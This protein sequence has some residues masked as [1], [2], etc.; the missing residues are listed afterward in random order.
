MT[1]DEAWAELQ[2]LAEAANREHW[3]HWDW[4]SW[5][6]SS[7]GYWQLD[8][9]QTTTNVALTVALTPDVVLRLIAA[10]R[11]REPAHTAAK[12]KT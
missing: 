3:D 2:Q 8:P 11:L 10:A 7:D 4:A 5:R 12:G 6:Q 9:G 1:L